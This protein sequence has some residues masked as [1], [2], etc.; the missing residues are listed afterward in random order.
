HEDRV[1]AWRVDRVIRCIAGLDVSPFVTG[2]KTRRS[3][4]R[5][6]SKYT[7]TVTDATAMRLPTA[8]PASP[9]RT[10][11]AL[12]TSGRWNPTNHDGGTNTSQADPVKRNDVTAATW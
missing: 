2:C 9:R 5:N 6:S 10:G 3:K 1:A 12:P 7:P 8:M 4:C 11:V